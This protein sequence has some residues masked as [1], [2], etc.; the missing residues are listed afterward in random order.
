MEVQGYFLAA[1]NTIILGYLMIFCTNA[2]GLNAGTV[3]V[4]L[5]VS[6]IFDGVTD[7]LQDILLI[8]RIQSSAR[9]GIMSS[10]FLGFG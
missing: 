6:K 5:L 3:G 9:R 10:V 7:L 1:M 8:I 4:L 2:L